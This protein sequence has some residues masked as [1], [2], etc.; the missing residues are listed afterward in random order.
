MSAYSN[1]AGLY[2]PTGDQI[3]NPNIT[4]QPIPV[5]TRPKT[6]DNVILFLFIDVSVC[7]SQVSIYI[8]F[9]ARSS[10][11]IVIQFKVFGIANG[12]LKLIILLVRTNSCAQILTLKYLA[13][14]SFLVFA[15]KC[16]SYQKDNKIT[17]VNITGKSESL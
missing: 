1:L 7:V 11:D 3:W 5:H 17:S 12:G 4:W 14:Y 10:T 9:P 16:P 13:F 8:H 15:S 6:E 2:P